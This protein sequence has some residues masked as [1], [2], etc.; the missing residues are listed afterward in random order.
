[1][2][3]PSNLRKFSLIPFRGEEDR[4]DLAITGQVA[5]QAGLLSV[6]CAILGKLSELAIPTPEETPG[7]KDALWKGTCL[8]LF[9]GAMGDEAYWEFNLSPGGDWNIYRFTTYRAGMREETAVS[10]LPFEVRTDS[11]A[12]HLSLSLDLA[13]MLPPGQ[14]IDVGVCAVLRST[15]GGMSHWALAHHGP[16]PDF[17]R[18][19]GF[20]LAFPADRS[21]RNIFP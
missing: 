13:A 20:A 6:R 14:A 3:G 10:S 16:R 17:H 18:R 9:I 1:M 7:R 2:T 21:A 19:E 11:D 5:R 15:A 4:P 8:E 12:L